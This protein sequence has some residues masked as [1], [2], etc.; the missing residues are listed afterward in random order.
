VWSHARTILL[1]ALCLWQ[2]PATESPQDHQLQLWRRLTSWVCVGSGVCWSTAT[3]SGLMGPNLH[4]FLPRGS[5]HSPTTPPSLVRQQ[6]PPLPPSMDFL[7]GVGWSSSI[8]YSGVATQSTH[9]WGVSSS[10][11][12]QLSV[13]PVVLPRMYT[14]VRILAVPVTCFGLWMMARIPLQG[15]RLAG[16]RPS[17]W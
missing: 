7:T 15:L 11:P 17:I 6:R 8:L 5:S 9:S 14:A 3:K 4:H 13:L 2:Q 1:Q 12:V 10:S 16:Q